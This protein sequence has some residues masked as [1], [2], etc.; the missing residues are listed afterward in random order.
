M[1]VASAATLLAFRS[2]VYIKQNGRTSFCQ[3]SFW[4]PDDDDSDDVDDDDNI[5][6]TMQNCCPCRPALF[7]LA[8]DFAL[9]VHMTLLVGRPQPH[10]LATVSPHPVCAGIVATDRICCWLRWQLYV[11]CGP[12]CGFR[13]LLAIPFWL[14]CV[15][16]VLR[17]WSGWGV[18][19]FGQDQQQQ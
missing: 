19:P 2:V 1:A 3:R 16:G 15:G 17:S 13:L 11:N 9:F 4:H 18:T 5:R 7:C 12:F 10:P 8:S 6:I 14:H